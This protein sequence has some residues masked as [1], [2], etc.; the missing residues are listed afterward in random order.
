MLVN[1]QVRKSRDKRIF[2]TEHI[3]IQHYTVLELSPQKLYLF[4]PVV[5]QLNLESSRYQDE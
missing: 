1:G 2:L 5:V 4:K 3:K